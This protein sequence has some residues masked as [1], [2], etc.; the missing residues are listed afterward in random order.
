MSVVDEQSI[1]EISKRRV[2][3]IGREI[4]EPQSTRSVDERPEL[5]EPLD[6]STN[7]NWDGLRRLVDRFGLGCVVFDD[8]ESVV[9]W[10][11]MAKVKLDIQGDAKDLSKDISAAFRRLTR[12]V[13]CRLAPS[14]LTWVVIAYRDGTPA[15]M[16]EKSDLAPSNRSIV[17]LL[18]RDT[19][20]HPNAVRMQQMFG[21]TS[22]ETQVLVRIACGHTLLEIARNRNLSRTTIRSHL[23]SLFAKTETRRQS[24]LIALIDS[25]AILP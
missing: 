6:G 3:Q 11:A 7:R 22:A 18:D 10:N 21:L 9:D 20:P 19:R 1:S 4:R 25:F 23:A 5:G 14:T 15:V 2:A 24:E 16:H 13:P 12:N 17:L 8:R